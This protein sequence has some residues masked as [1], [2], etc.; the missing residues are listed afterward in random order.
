MSE[1]INEIGSCFIGLHAVN[2]AV[3]PVRSILGRG[4]L[5][6][7][8]NTLPELTYKKNFIAVYVIWGGSVPSST[9]WLG[10]TITAGAGLLVRRR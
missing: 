1:N 8:I 4:R 3:Q 10:A 7:L 2:T 5:P 6:A 9:G